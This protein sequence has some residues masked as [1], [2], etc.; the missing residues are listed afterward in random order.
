MRF[1]FGWSN[2]EPAFL[3]NESW[4]AAIVLAAMLV[5]FPEKVDA[6]WLRKGQRKEKKGRTKE[7][8]KEVVLAR[9]WDSERSVSAAARLE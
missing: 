5:T 9:T 8:R 1:L 3:G 7:G 6:G 2:A 4:A